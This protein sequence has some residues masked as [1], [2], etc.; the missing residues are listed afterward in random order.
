MVLCG[1]AI[2]AT[3]SLVKRI[4]DDLGLVIPERKRSMLAHLQCVW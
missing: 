1:I 3:I 2:L 4:V